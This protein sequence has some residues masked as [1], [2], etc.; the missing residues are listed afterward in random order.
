MK[1]I[2]FGNWEIGIGKR[3]NRISDMENEG[4]VDFFVE[5]LGSPKYYPNEENV[6]AE[7][8]PLILKEMLK[9]VQK[10]Q[11]HPNRLNH[12]TTFAKR[13]YPTTYTMDHPLRFARSFKFRPTKRMN[14]LVRFLRRG[15]WGERQKRPEYIPKKVVPYN[16]YVLHRF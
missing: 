9:T 1:R 7:N 16:I 10:R 4:M 3:V 15:I 11:T 6:E 2:G 12:L 14:H 13:E 5:A 8:V